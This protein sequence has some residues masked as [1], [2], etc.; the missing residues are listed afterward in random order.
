MTGDDP[1]L[2]GPVLNASVL[3][4]P[5]GASLR[6]AH[7][8]LG[9]SRGRVARY[10]EDVA[11][12]AAVPPDAT[13]ADYAD[14]AALALPAAAGSNGAVALFGPPAP[15]PGWEVLNRL[16]CVQM[17]WD[18]P[19]P[20]LEPAPDAVRLGPRDVPEMLDLIERT[21]PGPFRAR[22]VELGAYYGLR[23]DGRLVALAG[24]RMH[25]PGWTE[26]SAVCTDPDH[27]GH[28]YAAALMA[29]VAVGIRA[30]GERPFLH[31]AAANP[32]VRLYERL[33]FT[34]RWEVP[35]VF[36]RPPLAP[37]PRSA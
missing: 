22:T 32:A 27:R 16:P 30:R 2:S 17:T 8:H 14:L 26:I 37:A 23:R 7:T 1:A 3:D 19:P 29:R 33:G 36:A 21:R 5:A 24:E 10:R 34:H 11:P 4:D 25:P 35:I 6:G 31:T 15:P 12:F 20:G 13:A 28:G 18:D 9:R